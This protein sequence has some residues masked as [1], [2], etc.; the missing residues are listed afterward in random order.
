MES[1]VPPLS[2]RSYDFERGGRYGV[3]VLLQFLWAVDFRDDRFGI[4][5]EALRLYYALLRRRVFLSNS[6]FKRLYY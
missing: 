5:F 6:V 1:R 4:Q 3:F 2:T